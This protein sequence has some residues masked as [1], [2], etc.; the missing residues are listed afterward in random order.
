VL[1]RAAAARSAE[2]PPDFAELR[3]SLA[4]PTALVDSAYI[5]A[6][7][8][9]GLEPVVSDPFFFRIA[10]RNGVVDMD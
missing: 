9:S 8:R 6:A 4:T 2:A 5:A 1:R 7:I 10:V 3:R